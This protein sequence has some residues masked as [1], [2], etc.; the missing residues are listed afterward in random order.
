[1]QQ[2]ECAG[3]GPDR[4]ALNIGTDRRK[5]QVFDTERTP[6]NE[7]DDSETDQPVGGTLLEQLSDAEGQRIY[8]PRRSDS[9]AVPKWLADE[10]GRKRGRRRI[11]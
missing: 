7:S 4:F 10:A 2:G 3:G 11:N 8:L 1:V 9:S 6:T 5:D